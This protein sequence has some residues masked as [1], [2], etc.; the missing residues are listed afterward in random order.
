MRE[1]LLRLCWQAD[2][3]FRAETESR[4]SRL[5]KIKT[6]P[7]CW[8]E[9]HVYAIIILGKLNISVILSG[10]EESAFLLSISFTPEKQILDAGER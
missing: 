2:I 9:K 4:D 6:D 7:V 3:V 10:S 5:V 8:K 1:G